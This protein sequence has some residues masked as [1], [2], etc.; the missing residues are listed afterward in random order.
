MSFLR[1][2]SAQHFSQRGRFAI[3]A[4]EAPVTWALGLNIVTVSC[5][6]RLVSR[7]AEWRPLAALQSPCRQRRLSRSCEGRAKLAGRSLAVSSKSSAL[8]KVITPV[9]HWLAPEGAKPVQCNCHRPALAKDKALGSWPVVSCGP[10][11][12]RRT[13][14]PSVFA[15]ASPGVASLGWE[16]SSPRTVLAPTRLSTRTLRDEAAQRRLHSR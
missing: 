3:R 2:N 15:A 1:K 4:G 8:P 7:R 6:P 5:L 11:V 13:P 16:A 12:R 14:A 9:S 10:S